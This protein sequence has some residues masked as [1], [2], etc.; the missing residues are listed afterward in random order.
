MKR[1]AAYL[2]VHCSGEPPTRIGWVPAPN[3]AAP[4][5]IR[6]GIGHTSTD[7]LTGVV[8]RAPWLHTEATWLAQGDDRQLAVMSADQPIEVWRKVP[9][10]IER[11]SRSGAIFR[12][13][14]PRRSRQRQ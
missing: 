8:T 1:F 4:G 12:A 13:A 10:F 11:V 7:L 14:V 5:P 3:A 6:F 2:P 9:G